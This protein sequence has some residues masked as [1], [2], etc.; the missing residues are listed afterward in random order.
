VRWRP[1]YASRIELF[2]G[3]VTLAAA[4]GFALQGSP[5]G[6]VAVLI[7]GGVLVAD[8][9]RRGGAPGLWLLALGS[10]ATLSRLSVTE[11]EATLGPLRIPLIAG[12][13][14]LAI[15]LGVIADPE[16]RSSLRRARL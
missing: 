2:I 8:A 14:V 11:T 10:C 1:Y 3:G 6:A 9:L 15:A 13:S 4:F 16:F 12:G 7:A 5:F